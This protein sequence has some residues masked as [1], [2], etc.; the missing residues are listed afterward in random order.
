[1]IVLYGRQSGPGRAVV[2]VVVRWLEQYTG[3]VLMLRLGDPGDPFPHEDPVPPHARVLSVL[4]PWKIPPTHLSDQSFNLH[5]GSK[6]Y[7]GSA[8]YNLALYDET[9]TYGVVLHRMAPVIDAGPIVAARPVVVHPADTVDTLR[10][11]AHQAGLALLWDYYPR[12]VYAPESLVPLPAEAQWT[13]PASTR[14]DIEALRRVRM[15]MS[16]AEISRRP[17]AITAPGWP[18]LIE[19]GVC[20]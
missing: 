6:D 4:C 15:D 17:R 5:P 1:M 16:G 3:Q 13:R 9:P 8:C 7:P 14:K 12:L 11:R 19:E 10:R 2:D 20:D 18:G